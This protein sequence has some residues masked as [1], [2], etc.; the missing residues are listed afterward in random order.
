MKIVDYPAAELFCVAKNAP[1]LFSALG[2]HNAPVVDRLGSEYRS[3]RLLL[4]S[5]VTLCQFSHWNCALRTYM[6]MMYFCKPCFISFLL[7]R[8]FNVQC[9]CVY[10]CVFVCFNYV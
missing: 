5:S 9:V 10:V 3:R 4:S 2:A 8:L 7:V 6:Y 1:D